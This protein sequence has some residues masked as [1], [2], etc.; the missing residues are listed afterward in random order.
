MRNSW[1]T[2]GG[3]WGA[4]RGVTV[5]REGVQGLYVGR[6]KNI[7]KLLRWQEKM[8]GLVRKQGKYKGV[9]LA[10]KEGQG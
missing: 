9:T 3:G 5:A 1:T 7:L 10:G 8:S 6:R 2:A 4:G